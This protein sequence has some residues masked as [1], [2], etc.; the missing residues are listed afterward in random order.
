MTRTANPSMST[1]DKPASAIEKRMANPLFVSLWSIQALLPHLP[2]LFPIAPG[3]AG[4]ASAP[5]PKSRYRSHYRYLGPQALLDALQHTT[6]SEFEIALHLIDF[7]PLERLLAQ[8]YVPSHKGQIP[9]HP[10]SMFLCIC[11]RRELNLSWRALASFRRKDWLG[12]TAL[13]GAPSLA[14]TKASLPPPQACATSSI[15]SV[16]RSSMTCALAAS[17]CCASAGF[18]L[19]TP[20]VP[21][22]LKTEG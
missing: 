21:M 20:P 8:V 11:L 17:R 22:I 9:F 16:P 18:A 4:A 5:S 14:S 7:S 3:Y 1:D 19:S 10:V 15:P 12:L 6:L 2:L 13:A